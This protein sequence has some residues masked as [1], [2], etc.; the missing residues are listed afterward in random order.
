MKYSYDIINRF[1]HDTDV[2]IYYL[3]LNGKCTFINQAGLNILGYQETELTGKNLHDL[4]HSQTASGTY[5]PRSQCPAFLCV[6]NNKIF[7]SDNEVFRHHSGKLIPVLLLAEPL[8][9]EGEVTGSIGIFQDLTLKNQLKSELQKN[10]VQLEN[11]NKLKNNFLANMSH[12]LRTPLNAIMGL[13]QLILQTELSPI[14]QRYLSKIDQSSKLLSVLINNIL[15][16]SKLESGRM[17]VSMTPFNLS[18]L[19]KDLQIKYQPKA[20]EKNLN[21]KVEMHHDVPVNRL[22]DIS[23]IKKVLM[24]LIGNAIKFTS[25]GEISLTIETHSTD[26]EQLVFH[27][28]DTG[29][30]IDPT[31]QKGIFEDFNQ[32]DASA[33]RH[34]KGLGL[35]LSYSKKLIEL[36]DGE[37]NLNSQLGQ[38]SHF[39]VSLKLAIDYNAT[40]QD[41]STPR[42][43]LVEDNKI[44]Q[45]IAKNLLAKQGCEVMIAEHG[46]QAIDILE[47]DRNF[48]LILMDIQMPVMDGVIATK[49]LKENEQ[50]RH[51]PVIALTGNTSSEEQ[52]EY[53]ES[54]M[55]DFLGKPIKPDEFKQILTTWGHIK[56]VNLEDEDTQNNSYMAA[57]DGI[58]MTMGLQ[59][60]AHNHQLY[61]Q[62]LI[63]YAQ[64][65]QQY[66]EKIQELLNVGNLPEAERLAHSIKGVVG[67]IGAKMLAEY[68]GNLEKSIQLNID[69]PQAFEKFSQE[70]HLI[71]KN[72][73]E[74][75][76]SDEAEKK[77]LTEDKTL[78][79]L[80]QK[81][82]NILEMLEHKL[83]AYDGDVE[84][85]MD[86]NIKVLINYFPQ[87]YLEKLRQFI[88]RYTYDDAVLLIR[89]MSD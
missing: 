62:L 5:L 61:K 66:D 55:S 60:L 20:V 72:L 56:T 8:V 22:G 84:E 38:G 21:L 41:S 3:D 34:Y 44:N 2:G 19:C 77:T 79:P 24:N 31:V 10:K 28:K 59:R 16:L 74:S 87:V 32:G 7:K 68:A 36:M 25:T 1:I 71:H 89:E 33:T 30:G 67:N 78:I 29:I 49:I 48:A 27:V 45:T 75:G 6:S 51:I 86:K 54:G 69:I 15:D 35:G 57:I 43:L 65:Y 42:V 76:Y 58:D 37:I 39:Y 70:F 88:Q 53:L 50:T 73:A 81:C 82:R 85:A 83:R 40:H 17:K 63:D 46:Q 11:I 14:Q 26:P 18:A 4:I 9:E 12:E 80:D 64:H 13:T 52:E 23:K 47:H